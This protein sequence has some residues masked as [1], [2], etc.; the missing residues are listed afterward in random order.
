MPE[1]AR[2]FEMDFIDG[3]GVLR[4]RVKII[5]SDRH[6]AER[7]VLHENPRALITRCVELAIGLLVPG[8]PRPN[9]DPSS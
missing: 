5:A 6:D 4:R 8:Q 7:R 9:S 1:I 3:H 2:Q